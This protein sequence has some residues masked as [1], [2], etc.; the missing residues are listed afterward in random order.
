MSL[1]ALQTLLPNSQKNSEEAREKPSFCSPSIR[2]VQQPKLCYAE[3]CNARYLLQKCCITVR[4]HL[5]IQS[6][7][8]MLVL[9]IKSHFPCGIC[10]CG[11][12]KDKSN[13]NRTA[14]HIQKVL[15]LLALLSSAVYTG[16][17]STSQN[18]Q[19]FTQ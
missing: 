14:I 19:E 10:F 5:S 18:H 15:V 16:D 3:N 8:Q 13:P 2:D 17:L 11:S 1:F 9:I 4:L 7:V 12:T 6:R